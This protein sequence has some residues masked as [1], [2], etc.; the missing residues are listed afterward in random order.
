MNPTSMQKLAPVQSPR[1]NPPVTP[2][3]NVQQSPSTRPTARPTHSV[4]FTTTASPLKD[5]SVVKSLQETWM[6][7]IGSGK[8]S[9]AFFIHLSPPTG[10]AVQ[11]PPKQFKSQKQLEQMKS[12]QKSKISRAGLRRA[13]HLQ[14]RTSRITNRFERIRYRVMLKK[15]RDRFR[16]IKL[17]GQI[18]YKHSAAQLNRKLH[19][20]SIID[21]CAAIVEHAK[22]VSLMFKVRFD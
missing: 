19:L 18:E 16:N 20:K 13:L 7:P 10:S 15:Q 3:Q 14:A 9:T 5:K 8:R 21:K 22:M 11:F 12:W 2:V 4:N 6:V 17:Q 1:N